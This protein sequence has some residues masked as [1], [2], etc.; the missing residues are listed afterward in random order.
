MKK[1]T[2]IMLAVAI[3]PLTLV[4]ACHDQGD[5]NDQPL[6]TE[7]F[8]QAQIKGSIDATD[9]NTLDFYVFDN[10]NRLITVASGKPNTDVELGIEQG[11]T[12]TVICVG[13]SSQAI[14]PPFTQNTTIDQ[15]LLSLQTSTFHDSLVVQSPPDLFWGKLIFTPQPPCQTAIRDTVYI[16]RVVA[17]LTIVTRNLRESLNNTTDTDFSYL[18]RNTPSIFSFSGQYTGPEAGYVPTSSFSSSTGNFISSNIY[19]FPVE[20]HRDLYIDI[21]KGNN[22]L[23]TFNS[24]DFDGQSILQAGKHTVIWID[25]SKSDDLSELSVV[26]KVGDWADLGVA[27]E[28]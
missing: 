6:T 25:Y 13:H 14:I 16:E 7:H 11:Q 1:S 24:Q 26:V 18:I 22:L 10:N 2:Q 15:A 23:R 12:A 28:F 4:Y 9:I 3:S 21:Y 27:E 5:H 20:F 19:T 17:S 8:V